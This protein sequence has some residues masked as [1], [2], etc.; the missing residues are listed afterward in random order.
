MIVHVWIMRLGPHIP[1]F[2]RRMGLALWLLGVIIA[3]LN[4]RMTQ[5]YSNK[6]NSVELCKRREVGKPVNQNENLG[7]EGGSE[8]GKEGMDS[9]DTWRVEP[10]RNIN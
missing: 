8:T 9:R 1:H 4:W 10:T 5:I 3:P 7:L 6:D 2:S